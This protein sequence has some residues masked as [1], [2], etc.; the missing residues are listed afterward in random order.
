MTMTKNQDGLGPADLAAVIAHS[1]IVV[2]KPVTGP[3]LPAG[4]GAVDVAI[5]E[6]IA[7]EDLTF[8]AQYIQAQNFRSFEVYLI[9]TFAYLLLAVLLRHACRLIGRRLFR[10]I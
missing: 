2:A 7:A 6:W 4:F 10:A 5:L 3:L 9:A 1:Q 8:A